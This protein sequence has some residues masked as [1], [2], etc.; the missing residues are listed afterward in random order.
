MHGKRAGLSMRQLSD[1]LGQL[2]SYNAI[3]KYED[4]K[5]IPEKGVLLALSEA[6]KVKPS[7]FSKPIQFDL[8]DIE[9]RKKSSLRVRQIDQIKA[10]TRDL[11]ERYIEVETLLDIETTFHNPILNQRI[12]TSQSVEAAANQIRDSWDL[13]SNPIPNV[14]E[15]L[16]EQEVKVLEIEASEKF[17]GLSTFVKDIPITILNE[18]FSIEKKAIYCTP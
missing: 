13:G 5:M 18:S 2:V 6:L 8:G 10:Q 16:E 3:K 7:Y 11:L 1:A 15:M 12:E 14:I 17:D 4:G 9:F